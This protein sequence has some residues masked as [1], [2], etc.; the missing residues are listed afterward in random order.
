MPFIGQPVLMAALLIISGL[1]IAPT[2]IALTALTQGSVPPA[3]LSEAL[4]WTQTGIAVGLAAS[5]AGLGL[6]I[7]RYGASGGLVG[8]AA[9]GVLAALVTLT[10]RSTRG[11]SR[12]EPADPEVAGEN[13]ADEEE[14]AR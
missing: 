10:V 12:Q 2:L 11:V 5:G 3:R 4:S 7:D 13:T 9:M 14:R 6:I 1:F 8:I